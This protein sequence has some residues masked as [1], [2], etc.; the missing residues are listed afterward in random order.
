MENT[1]I[2]A[3]TSNK[4]ENTASK[5]HSTDTEHHSINS[6]FI[7]IN[8]NEKLIDVHE[9]HGLC[10]TMIQ[11]F[12]LPYIMKVDSLRLKLKQ[13]LILKFYVIFLHVPRILS[14]YMHEMQR[15]CYVLKISL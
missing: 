9:N 3:S 2:D 13:Y 10:Y 7:E 11:F 15:V 6:N 4:I 8:Q 14:E 5:N 12:F 1:L